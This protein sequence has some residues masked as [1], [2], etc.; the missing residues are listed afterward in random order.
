M[1][2]DDNPASGAGARGQARGR[3]C[4]CINSINSHLIARALARR[5]QAQPPAAPARID[6]DRLRARAT[7]CS[8]VARPAAT[9]FIGRPAGPRP[10]SSAPSRRRIARAGRRSSLAGGR[11]YSATGGRLA[12]W[13][14]LA[15]PARPFL[16]PA[17][18][19]VYEARDCARP[20]GRLKVGPARA[21]A[22]ATF[23]ANGSCSADSRHERT[24]RRVRERP[25]KRHVA[26]AP[27][28]LASRTGGPSEIVYTF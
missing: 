27:D 2:L 21:I 25:A 17:A 1:G 16:G 7:S 4:I 6:F 12:V 20:A 28:V 8:S 13:V 14:P 15:T 26:P 10:N 19:R 5:P 3:Q 11:E 18:R 23:V 22:A 24:G 9:L